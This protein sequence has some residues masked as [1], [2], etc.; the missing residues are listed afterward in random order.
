LTSSTPAARTHR[1]T[2]LRR[3]GERY[4]ADGL[5]ELPDNR[6]ARETGEALDAVIA[7]RPG[8]EGLGDLVSRAAALANTAA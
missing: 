2:R 8:W 6:R 5:R 7:N 3:Q 4:F 1:I